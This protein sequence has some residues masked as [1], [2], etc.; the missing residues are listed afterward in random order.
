MSEEKIETLDQIAEIST[1][2]E[3]QQEPEPQPTEP[4]QPSD[5]EPQNEPQPQ[6]DQPQDVDDQGSGDSQEDIKDE[7]SK[8]LDEALNSIT[9]GTEHNETKPQQPQTPQQAPGSQD[10][11]S[12]QQQDPNKQPEKP[13]T[14]AEEEAE[15]LA[16][17]GNERSRKRFEKILHERKEAREVAQSF[18]QQI[19]GAGY[20]ERTFAQVLEFG[21][22]LSSS[23]NNDKKAAMAMLDQVRANL[24]AELGQEVPGVDLLKD[25]PDLQKEVDSMNLDRKRALEIAAARRQQQEQAHYNKLEAE[26]RQWG[27]R[28]ESARQQMSTALLPMQKDPYFVQKINAI[29]AW[30]RTGDNMVNFVMNVPPEQWT[31]KIQQMYQTL[32]S[33]FYMTPSA[34]AKPRSSQ[35]Q[36][37]RSRPM[38]T[39]VRDTSKMSVNEYALDLMKD[40]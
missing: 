10:K 40:L 2:G 14:E 18:V 27:Q 36:P 19:R 11:Q 37:L 23:D 15:I 8:R 3:P 22:L 12:G 38:N 21:R 17:A 31:A 29:H 34:Q 30:L 26:Q 20:D 25:Y 13:K 9:E 28:L 1:P 7:L 32:P 24:A 39:G 16:M 6:S 35:P 4:Q 33:Q 5:N